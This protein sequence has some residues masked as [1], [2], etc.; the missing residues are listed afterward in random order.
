MS[1]AHTE[2]FE[3]FTIT[4]ECLPEDTAPQ[5]CFAG[6]PESDAETFRL[7]ESGFYLW[8]IAKVSASREGVTLATDYLGGCCYE[9]ADQFVK[10]SLGY[11]ED[12]RRTVVDAA[13]ATITKLA[14]SN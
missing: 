11:F 1:Y 5:D 10:E 14:Q 7:I 3:G 6:D 2:E 9:S 12:M 8:F 4:L 13:R